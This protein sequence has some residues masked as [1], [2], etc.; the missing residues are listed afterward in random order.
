MLSV[1]G[2]EYSKAIID[3]TLSKE[4]LELLLNS[5]V[6]SI[7]LDYCELHSLSHKVITTYLRANVEPT[8]LPVSFRGKLCSEFTILIEGDVIGNEGTIL[9][10]SIDGQSTVVAVTLKQRHHSAHAYNI[11]QDI[12][13]TLLMDIEHRIGY[14]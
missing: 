13:H 7:E 8:P 9:A 4:L 3:T 11:S 1:L 6:Q 10:H 12:E 14:A 2:N 5:D